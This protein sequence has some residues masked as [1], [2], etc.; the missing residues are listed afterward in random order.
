[1]ESRNQP[2]RPVIEVMDEDVAHVIRAKSG[3][4]RLKIASD[5]YSRTREML[6]GQLKAQH[7]DWDEKRLM[8]EAAKILSHGASEVAWEHREQSSR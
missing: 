3:A 2:R 6:M 7:P 1:M 8:R 4:E 5:I